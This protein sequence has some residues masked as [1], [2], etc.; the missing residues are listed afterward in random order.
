LDISDW[1]NEMDRIDEQLV[2]LLNRRTFCAI[3]IGKIKH[4]RGL[5]IYAP[6]REMQVLDHVSNKNQGPL[7]RDAIR[8]LFERIIDEARSI[9]RITVGQDSMGAAAEPPS[10]AETASSTEGKS[11]E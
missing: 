1:R 9:E 10:D 8:R 7:D 5:P 11:Q 6:E 3:Q 4:E 2:E